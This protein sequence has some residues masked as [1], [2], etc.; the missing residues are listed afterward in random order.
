MQ[1]GHFAPPSEAH[2]AM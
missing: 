2:D 1:V